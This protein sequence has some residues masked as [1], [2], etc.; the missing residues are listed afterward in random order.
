MRNFPRPI[1]PKIC[2]NFGTL[3]AFT[4]SSIFP[5]ISHNFGAFRECG[6]HLHFLLCGGRTC[7]TFSGAF[8]LR[9]RSCEFTACVFR[10]FECTF[11]STVARCVFQLRLKKCLLNR[12]QFPDANFPKN[13]FPTNLAKDHKCGR[14]CP[15][16]V[17]FFG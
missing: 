11:G 12:A 9:F 7:T 3:G 17:G 5:K 15:K 10:S 8:V 4:P 1:F 2:R 16:N 13:N 14:F 6:L